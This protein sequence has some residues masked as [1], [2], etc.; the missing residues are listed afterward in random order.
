MACHTVVVYRGL[1]PQE[2]VLRLPV[3]Q[4]S[5]PLERMCGR[6]CLYCARNRLP[7][8]YFLKNEKTDFKTKD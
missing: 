3:H 5:P 4:V 8:P 6:R 7:L 2:E 1:I